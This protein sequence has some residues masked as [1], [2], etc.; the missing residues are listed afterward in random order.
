SAPIDRQ[1]PESVASG[2]DPMSERFQDAFEGFKDK[3]PEAGASRLVTPQAL[4]EYWNQQ[5]GMYSPNDPSSM[6]RFQK[7]PEW[8]RD[9]IASHYLFSRNMDRE[10][11]DARARRQEAAKEEANAPRPAPS[12]WDRIDSWT[13]PVRELLK[14]RRPFDK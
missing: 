4:M 11:A 2:P 3:K 7:Q 9:R 6:A 12:I 8:F 5:T 1:A 10:F 13:A 14:P